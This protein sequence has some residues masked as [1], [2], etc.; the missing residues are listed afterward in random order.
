MGNAAREPTV[1]QSLKFQT[2]LPWAARGSRCMNRNWPS[3]L[4]GS[5]AEK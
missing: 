3:L 1:T 2:W 4:L 5:E